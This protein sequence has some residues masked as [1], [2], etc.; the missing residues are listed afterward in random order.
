[1]TEQDFSRPFQ[2]DKL[3]PNPKK[4]H[5]QADET[6]LKALKKRFSLDEIVN[7][8]GEVMLHRLSGKKIEVRFQAQAHITQECVVTFKPVETDIKLEFVRIYDSSLATENEEKEIEIDIESS[9]ELDPIIDGM[10]DLGQA[11]AEELGL[12]VPSFPRAD[13]TEFQEFGIGPE[14]TQ[15]EVNSSNPFSVLAKLKQ[16][17]D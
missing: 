9:E 17:S 5:I 4:I 11:L 10:I 14:I 7:F 12:E 13:N 15:E 8:E 2:V 16:K 3:G 6:E 1:M